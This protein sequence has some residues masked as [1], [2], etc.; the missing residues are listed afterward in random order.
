M[1]VPKERS[2]RESEIYFAFGKK[3]VCLERERERDCQSKDL[4]VSKRG[5]VPKSRSVCVCARPVARVGAIQKWWKACSV[6][7]S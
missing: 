5:T 7:F 2:E 4:L 6:P 3:C 1:T